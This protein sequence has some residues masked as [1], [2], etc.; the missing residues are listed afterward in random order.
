MKVAGSIRLFATP[1][2]HPRLGPKPALSTPDYTPNSAPDSQ[3]PPARMSFDGTHDR[4]VQEGDVVIVYSS[5]LDQTALTVKR[6]QMYNCKYGTF[7]HND[8]IGTQFG[9]K[10]TNLRKDGFVHLLYPTPELWTQVVPHR[11]QILYF[12]DISFVT[13]QLD[14]GPGSVVVESGTTLWPRG[15]ETRW[16]ERKHCGA[17]K[18]NNIVATWKVNWPC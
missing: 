2:S 13:L 7:R 9:A 10:V 8:M 4:V 17:V 12:A 1:L 5:P 6:D 16:R 11:T 15:R 18:G 14:L 3:V